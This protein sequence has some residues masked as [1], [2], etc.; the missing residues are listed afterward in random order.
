MQ[1]QVMRAAPASRHRQQTMLET[2]VR[3]L[4][5]RRLTPQLRSSRWLPLTP[6]MVST[7]RPVGVVAFVVKVRVELLPVAG[8]GAN[9]AV[10]PHD[11]A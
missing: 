6:V 3:S 1:S 5:A 7:Q 8:S 9:E 2:P 10:A 4:W 11:A